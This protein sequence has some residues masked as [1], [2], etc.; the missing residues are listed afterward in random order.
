MKFNITLLF[1][2]LFVID[3]S[4]KAQNI[5]GGIDG[6]YKYQG[7][8]NG[9]IP[10]FMWFAVKDSVLKGEVVYLKTGSHLPI[11][12]AGYISKKYGLSIYE[13]MKDGNIT[14]VYYGN[15]NKTR[16]TGT[17][18]SPKSEKE[19]KYDLVKKDT[20][21]VNKDIDLNPI[22][23]N[24]EYLYKFGPKGATGGIDLKSIG[25][26]NYLM[27]INCVTDG[28]AYNQADVDATKVKI[29]NNAIIYS[30]DPEYG[31]CRF[32][33]KVLKDFIV[34]SLISGEGTCG[35]GNN[36][37]IVGVYFKTSEKA[38][39]LTTQH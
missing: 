25:Q 28:P 15:F 22:A 24:G 7:T 8:I 38:T 39:S 33:I 31:T 10:M 1:I 35:F 36:A 12:I 11:N 17:W 26:N 20:V 21:L 14:G 2:L 16:L 37:T 29:H 3:V 4:G 32:R 13:F 27:Q 6:V 18:Y 9:K 34:I 19:L 23:V 30:T 5:N